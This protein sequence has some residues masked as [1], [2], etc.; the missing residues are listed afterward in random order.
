M[1]EQIA[2]Q[3]D[4]LTPRPPSEQTAMLDLLKAQTQQQEL[5]TQMHVEQQA[6]RREIAEG[7]KIANV[8]M[9]FWALVGFIMKVVLASIPAYILL[10]ILGFIVFF[11]VSA[12]VA[13]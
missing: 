12:F 1:E 13:G 10:G 7:V 8:N 5:L 3:P 4:S 6:Q 11:V 2:V 9:P